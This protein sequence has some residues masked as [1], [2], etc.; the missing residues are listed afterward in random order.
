[1]IELKEENTKQANKQTIKCERC[2]KR[3]VEKHLIKTR[4]KLKKSNEMERKTNDSNDLSSLKASVCSLYE[5]KKCDLDSKIA[6]LMTITND[7][8]QFRTIACLIRTNFYLEN[9]IDLYFNNDFDH[10]S[11]IKE[12]NNIKI[13]KASQSNELQ[14]VQNKDKMEMKVDL[15]LINILKTMTNDEIS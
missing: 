13:N 15:E 12:I 1:M 4:R 6:S 14:T 9:A 11:A 3:D 2:R 10:K 8:E 5:M 7:K